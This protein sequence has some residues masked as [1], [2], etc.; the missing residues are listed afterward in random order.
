MA[1]IYDK[2]GERV[3]ICGVRER[4]Q[5][6][7]EA[8]DWLD[9]RVGFFLSVT[10][11]TGDDTITGLAEDIGA[12]DVTPIGPFD[13]FAIGIINAGGDVFGGFTNFGFGPIFP[14]SFGRT[15]LVASNAA[16]G[17]G[18]DYWR[19]DNASSA[20]LATQL[21]SAGVTRTTGDVGERLHLAQ[22]VVNAGGYAA[23]YGLRF[24]RPDPRGRARIITMQ[25][26]YSPPALLFSNTPTTDIIESSL[27]A[28]PTTNIHTLGPVELS[29]VPD[30][31]HVYWPFH[32]SRIRIHSAGILKAS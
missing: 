14:P 22:N 13:R 27:E 3:L 6:P 11:D 18:T 32:N 2:A 16:D 4:F 25:V 15:R 17:A 5:Q 12:N 7:F 29:G 23:L 9:L 30:R 28:W 1:E 24:T 20:T 8:T 31:L 10:D 21:I 26:K 19:V